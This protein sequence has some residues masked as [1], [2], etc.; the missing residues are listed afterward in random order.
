MPVEEA[1]VG[2]LAGKVGKW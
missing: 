1:K 2:K